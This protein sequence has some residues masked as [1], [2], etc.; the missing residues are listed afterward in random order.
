VGEVE[1]T[2][3][4]LPVELVTPVP[5]LATGRVPVTPEVSGKPVQ[6]VSVPDD[7]VPKAGVTKT[8]EVESTLL[9]LPVELV[10]PVPPF[11]TG[12]VPVT[13]VVSGKPVQLVSVPE[14]GVPKIG[15]TSVGEVESTLLPLP[16][17]LVT[18][19]PPFATG[20]VP[21]ISPTGTDALAVITVVPL[22]FT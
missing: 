18:P 12:R 8:G 1:R 5:P 21:E 20:R 9:P 4:P 10:T 7:G 14:V 6:L 13:P 15:V 16:V 3:L 19:V 17:E 22:A 11:A 2:L